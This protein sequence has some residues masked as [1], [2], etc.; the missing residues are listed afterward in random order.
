M[1]RTHFAIIQ[2]FSEDAVLEDFTPQMRRWIVEYVNLDNLKKIGYVSWMD[3]RW[4]Q[5]MAG[6]FATMNHCQFTSDQF[7]YRAIQVFGEAPDSGQ[8]RDRAT[9]SR[10]AV[11]SVISGIVHRPQT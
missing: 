6:P 4:M 9:Q 10:G 1:P 11:V 8:E 7:T 3:V 5:G 2:V